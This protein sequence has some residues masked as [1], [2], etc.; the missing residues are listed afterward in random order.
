MSNLETSVKA[1]DFHPLSNPWTLYAH[2]PHDVDWS[3]DSYKAILKFSNV[4]EMIAL[5]ET[6]PE[7]MIRN[8]MLFLMKNNIKPIWEDKENCNGGSFSYKISN[9]RVHNVWT[10]LSYL[11]VG[12]TLSNDNAFV[13]N[14]NG[15]TISPKKN[16][17]IIKLWT[18]TCDYEQCNIFHELCDINDTNVLFRKHDPEY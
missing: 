1:D 6:M 17:C 2:M 7:L 3:L 15:I 10:N 14:I 11:L 16:F 18:K 9:D 4:E 13:E 12:K 8:C 5:Y